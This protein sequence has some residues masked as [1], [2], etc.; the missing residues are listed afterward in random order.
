MGWDWKKTR[1]KITKDRVGKGAEVFA[2]TLIIITAAHV[3]EFIIAS[4]YTIWSLYLIHNPE[5]T[6]RI[7]VLFAW[8][9][10]W[11]SLLI[12]GLVLSR[13]KKKEK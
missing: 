7:Y 5:Q 4:F 3:M 2:W 1:W 13:F 12:V 6:D 8:L 9:L 10:L 11:T